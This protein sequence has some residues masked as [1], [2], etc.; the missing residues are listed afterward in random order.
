MRRNAIVLIALLV[1]GVMPA[2]PAD[3]HVAVAANFTAPLQKLAPM[4]EQASGNKLIISPGASGQL[5][6]QI[7][8]GAPFDVFLSADTDKPRLLESEGLSVPDS[9]F[10]YAVGS[11]VLWSPRPD[12]VDG[13]G[14]I[15]K[16]QSYHFIGVAN[17]QTAPYGT[18]AQQV[19]TQLDLWDRLNREHRIVIGENI[20]QA[21]QF[22]ATGNAELAFVALSQ[23]L[24]ED[25]RISGS[26]WRVPQSMYDPIEQAAVIIAGTHQQA[27][28][29]AF[30]TWLG[31]DPAA[32]AA[33]RAAGYRTAN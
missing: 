26:S 2:L 12:L 15:L 32:L 17:P 10:I 1:V 9:R 23:V 5:Y 19:L 22:A 33:I 28:A 27:A 7:K 6:A 25:G 31:T 29:A 13:N 11:L 18:A 8:Q 24:G 30:V 20:T 3:L 4:F 21:W 16:S 14:R